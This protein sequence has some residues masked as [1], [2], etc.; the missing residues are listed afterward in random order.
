MSTTRRTVAAVLVAPALACLSTTLPLAVAGAGAALLASS[1]GV[2]DGTSTSSAITYQGQLR[3]A[4][5]PFTGT[6]GV[7]RFE[8][9]DAAGPTGQP[10]GAP[11]DLT[12]VAVVDGLITVDLDFGFLAFSGE[13]RW[14]QI[15]VDGT[16][17]TPRQRVAA[18]A[19]ALFALNGNEGPIGPQGPAGPAGQVGPIGPAGS[20]GATG[21]AGA[22]GPQGP[23]GPTGPAGP[24]GAAGPQGLQGPQGPAGSNSLWTVNGSAMNYTG[25]NVSVGTTLQQGR[26]TVY[27]AVGDGG[28]QVGLY[29]RNT[30]ASQQT[31]SGIFIADST[32][33]TALVGQATATAG[34]TRAISATNASSNGTAVYG[35]ATASTGTTYGVWGRTSSNSGWAGFFEGRGHFS[36]TTLVGRTTTI[37]SAEVFGIRS[38]ALS[39]YGGMYA[40]VAGANGLP[41]YG[42]ATNGTAL[43]WTYMDGATS[44]W[45][46]NIG[47]TNRMSVQ[48]N[49]NVAI[50][51]TT[52]ATRLHVDGGSDASLTGGGFLVAG[53]TSS[54]NVVIDNNEIMA[55]SNGAV[56]PL[57]LN[58]NGGEVRIGQ[59]SGG[60]GRLVTPVLQITGG[61]DL[62][63]G[64]DVASVAGLEPEA[65]MIVCID[66]ANPGKLI[67]SSEAYDR[68]VAGIISGANG[69]KPGM[70]MG[71]EN[72]VAD[73]RHPV[74]LTGRVYVLADAAHGTIQPGDLMTTSATPGHAMKA[75]D[76]ERSPGAILG[77]AMSR[78]DEGTGYVLVLVSLQ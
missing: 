72:T 77:K 56:A 57:S 12:N 55:R 51:T 28:T 73:G 70:V 45:H 37:G 58:H 33:G 64:F 52:A 21:P 3:Q 78:L 41:F 60:T 71:Q 34:A 50:G 59:G 18:A 66:P 13:E 38:P 24:Q 15:T 42:Y 47:G 65:G 16:P 39:G 9:F 54:L 44:N 22:T 27:P 68:R 4:G 26:L 74:A 17:L 43:G 76:R 10:I 48:P 5:V 40:D 6:I 25:G 1:A 23:A 31:I 11:I 8:L 53:A 14:I 67:L 35:F 20:Q 30:D 49:G 29:V 62:A 32:A 61:S 75:A 19:Y 63:E 36:S 2:A 69:I 7:L 46:V